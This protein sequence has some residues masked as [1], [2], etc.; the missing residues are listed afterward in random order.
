MGDPPCKPKGYAGTAETPCFRMN[1]PWPAG[2]PTDDDILDW[3]HRVIELE[4]ARGKRFTTNAVLYYARHFWECT[5]PEFQRVKDLI[6]EH[7]GLS[8]SW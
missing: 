6:L 3:Y 5:S 4:A 1:N 8:N 2:Q 7:F